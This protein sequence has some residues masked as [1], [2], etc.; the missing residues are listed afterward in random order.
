MFNEEPHFMGLPCS[1]VVVSLISVPCHWKKL[2]LVGEKLHGV[3]CLVLSIGNALTLQERELVR[4]RT[5][6]TAVTAAGDLGKST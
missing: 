5:C 6:A 1:L 2:K 4:S 3:S